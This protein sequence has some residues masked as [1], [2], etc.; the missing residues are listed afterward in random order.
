MKVTMTHVGL[1]PGAECYTD[2]EMGWNE[3]FAGS[4][5]NYLTHHAG[6]PV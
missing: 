3:H 5:V 1:V 6:M 2:C 4:L